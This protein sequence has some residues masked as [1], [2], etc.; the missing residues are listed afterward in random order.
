M[1]GLNHRQV[2]VLYLVGEGCTN[3]QIAKRLNVGSGVVRGLLYRANR[4][5]GAETRYQAVDAARARGVLRG[6]PATPSAEVPDVAQ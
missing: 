3:R 6:G 2:R 4:A 5:L 1:A